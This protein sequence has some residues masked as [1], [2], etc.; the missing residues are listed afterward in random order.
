M[1]D[2]E[3]FGGRWDW[4]AAG[5]SGKRVGSVEIWG[6]SE[7]FQGPFVAHLCL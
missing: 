5:G 7:H 1:R 4:K 2:F 3:G 6:S